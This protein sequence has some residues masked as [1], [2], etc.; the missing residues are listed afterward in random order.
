MME[1]GM[2]LPLSKDQVRK[3]AVWMHA[4]FAPEIARAIDGKPYSA[5]IVYA[6]A[7]KE[8]GFIWI[9]RTTTIPPAEL[10]PLLIGDASGD[11][12]GHSRNAFP[13]N[14]GVFRAEFGDAFTDQLIDASNKARAL[15]S[16]GAAGIVYKGYGIFQ[17]DLQH[18]MADEPFFRNQLWRQ[19]DGCL[20]RLTRELDRC[21]A[22]AHGDTHDAV[23]RYNGSGSQAEIYADHVMAFADFCSGVG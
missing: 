7:C 2:N 17:Y 21:F 13:Q 12:E 9:S 10:L 11:V 6:I 20:D 3:G 22:A 15:R 23:R 14:T 5:A 16:L 1:S 18:V 8:T 4:N 19:I